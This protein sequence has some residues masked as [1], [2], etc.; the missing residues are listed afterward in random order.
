MSR[1]SFFERLGGLGLAAVALVA[2]PAL[3]S[4]AD[5]R[6][7][8]I[9][10]LYRVKGVAEPAIAPDG[11]SVAFAVT[12]TD[13]PAAHRQ[14]NLWR[15]DADGRNARA[16][17]VSDKRDSRPAFSPDGTILAFLSTRGGDPQVFFLPTAGGEAE[18]RT[19]VPGGV[20]SFLFTPDGKRLVIAAEVWPECGADMA[21]NRRNDEA[22]EKGKMKAHLAD[23]LLFRHWDAWE[24]GKRT[25]LLAVDLA[26]AKAPLRDLTPGDFD[27]P[28]FTVGGGTDYDVSPDGRELVFTS[29]RD[30]QP[31]SSTNV[32]LWVVPIDGS[33]EALAAPRNI[34]ASNR[35]FDGSPRYSPDGRSIGYTKQRVP[36]YE[37]DRI[38]L[39]LYDRAT[40]TSRV[41]T[42]G[43]DDWVDA[44]RFAP[45]G[46]R[47]FFTADVKG[48]TPLHALDLAT[49]RIAVVSSV[50]F[51]DGFEVSKDGT[52]AAVARRRMHEPTE[53]HRVTLTGEAAGAGSALTSQNQALLDEVDFRPMEEVFVDG[54]AG[55]V[56]VLLVKPHG[57][58]P[59]KKYP[60]I[61]NVHGGPQMQ[62]ADAFRGDAQVYPGAGYVVAFP[63]PHGSTG[64]GQD[65]TAEISGDWDGKVMQDV[66]AVTGWLAAQ[67]WV[68]RDRMGAMGWS[69]GGYATMWLAGHTDRFQ[70]LASMMGVYDLRTMYSSTEE[71]WFPEWDLKGTPWQNPEA[72][73]KQS[74]SSYVPRFRTPTLVLTGEKDFRVPYSQS[75]AFFT[76]LQKMG[77]P[78]RLVVFAGSGH[79]P[80]WYDMVLYYAAH[81]DWF[82]TYL[83]GEASPWDPKALV[84]NTVFAGEKGEKEE[85]E[86]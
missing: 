1:R 59:A 86:R 16:L 37:S 12:T 9:A 49:G 40:G 58:D 79:W 56:Q 20:A 85:G 65:Y 83:G 19:D 77:V 34:T 27:S 73:R 62:W 14:T 70:A 54:P 78:S 51:V 81:L 66:M 64:W 35:A 69:W 48:R 61:V 13:L 74:P 4:A 76:D 21:C 17:T 67:P 30:P 6:A 47:I 60:T 53:L 50:G 72:Y 8:T 44:F 41:L 29:K 39:A 11:R 63:N 2:L 84:R 55:K 36:G 57:F 32:D 25:H 45:D 82:H 15:A 80:G 33:A 42:E 28:A 71:L 68:D 31:A 22:M 5:R 43:F 75:L 7:A 24:D 23:H 3:A 52:W 38:V 46:K 26:H 18:R 10:D